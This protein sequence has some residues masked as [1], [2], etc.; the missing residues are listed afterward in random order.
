M[1]QLKLT[2]EQGITVTLEECFKVGAPAESSG[3][4]LGLS[5]AHA[6]KTYTLVEIVRSCTR[7]PKYSE[8]RTRGTVRIVT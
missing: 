3:T 4:H 8:L 6:A 2:S 5:V 1:K 7:R